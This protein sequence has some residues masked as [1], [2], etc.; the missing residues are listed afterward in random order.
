MFTRVSINKEKEAETIKESNGKC[1]TFSNPNLSRPWGQSRASGANWHLF[2]CYFC[3]EY[4]NDFN[5]NIHKYFLSPKANCRLGEILLAL[6]RNCVAPVF[7]LGVWLLCLIQACLFQTDVKAATLVRDGLSLTENCL[8]PQSSPDKCRAVWEGDS[9]R[10]QRVFAAQAWQPEF[11][12][13][14]PHKKLNMR[15]IYNLNIP[16]GRKGGGGGDRGVS[17]TLSCWGPCSLK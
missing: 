9:E 4:S 2:S 10:A 8:L 16:P 5:S 14:K 1:S 7:D 13:Q 11:D 3:N 12:T 15:S 6:P 17:Q